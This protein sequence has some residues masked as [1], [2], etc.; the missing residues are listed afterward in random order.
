M[1][2]KTENL[3]NGSA[4]SRKAADQPKKNGMYRPKSKAS[5]TNSNGC[6][7]RADNQ[8]PSTDPT[9]E[10]DSFNI[11]NNTAGQLPALRA[12][13]HFDSETPC[14]IL[15]LAGCLDYSVIR[16]SKSARYW[17]FRASSIGV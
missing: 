7:Q 2:T 15:G 16:L 14:K 12:Y 5:V 13:I 1:I 8:N 17:S 6:R 9:T 11:E 10:K 3:P 4:M